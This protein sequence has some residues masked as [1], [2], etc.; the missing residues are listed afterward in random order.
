MRRKKTNASSFTFPPPLSLLLPSNQGAGTLSGAL[1]AFHLRSHQV[2][3]FPWL[4]RQASSPQTPSILTHCTLANGINHEQNLITL[5][6]FDEQNPMKRAS[7]FRI[8]ATFTTR[9]NFIHPQHP[10]AMI[11]FQQYPQP[12]EPRN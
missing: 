6:L 5:L 9:R 12:K 11:F 1:R 2:S 10:R 7:F 8:K 3:D 4:Q